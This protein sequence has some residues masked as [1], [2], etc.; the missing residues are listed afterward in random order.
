MG[1]GSYGRDWA[2]EGNGRDG[3]E[4][5]GTGASDGPSSHRREEM[6]SLRAAIQG[7][8]EGGGP[9]DGRVR[10]AGGREEEEGTGEDY[11]KGSDH[12]V[13]AP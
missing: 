6:A 5:P 8:G 3:V 10:R 7:D 4:G 13:D 12:K 2:W 1:C 9:D 11:N